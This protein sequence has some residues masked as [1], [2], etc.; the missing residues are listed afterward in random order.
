VRV[1]LLKVPP[2]WSEEL[3]RRLQGEERAAGRH[4]VLL[5]D[6]LEALP[7]SL[8][9]GLLVVGDAGGPVEELV[10]LCEQL[11]ARRDSART[12]VLVL[13]D[14]GS[15]ELERLAGAGVD[16]LV[17]P[18]GEPWSAR[19]LILERR[20]GP[21][22][23]DSLHALKTERTQSRNFL[24]N[25]LEAFPDPLL[26]KDQRH[27]WLVVNTA[28]CRMLGMTEAQLLGKTDHDFVPAHQGDLYWAQDDEVLRTRKPLETEQ[29]YEEASGTRHLITQKAAFT[30]MTGEPYVVVV[31][32]DVTVRRRLEQQL[33]LAD[34]MASV[35][36]LAAGV[37]HEINNPLAYIAANLSYLADEL[38][39]DAVLPALLPELRHAVADSLEGASRVREIILQLRT[40]TRAADDEREPMNI[41]RT[42]EGALYLLR[43]E[44]T[45]HAR[46]E[47]SLEPVQAVL[48][49]EARLEQIIVHLL[50][51]ALQALPQRPAE[52]NL[53]RVSARS[54]QGWVCIEVEDN[55][56]GMTPEVQQRIF[57]PFF[58]TR[59]EKGRTGLG[60]S[61]SLALAQLMGGWIDVRSTP[62]RGS[63][64][65][66]RLPAMKEK[67]QDGESAVG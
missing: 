54:E 35:G 11:H 26:I 50:K 43:S 58:T 51:N 49:S 27:R 15:A 7:E 8:P 34:R 4:E 45:G 59:K 6:S 47:P 64:F 36:T 42:I 55:G 62:G 41:H 39:K 52:Q 12:H 37:A 23:G 44:L 20:L 40:F 18:P 2:R 9:A 14:R 21:H 38:E 17:A 5:A 61:I 53:I 29:T 22:G 13:T 16:E 3:E 48:G 33:R 57:D 19:L 63:W 46:V 24:R 66:L 31:V 30:G 25:A 60:L 32:R 10:R 67:A 65:Q 1:M 56:Q 28:F